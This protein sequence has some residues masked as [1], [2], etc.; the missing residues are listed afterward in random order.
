MNEIKIEGE[1]KI[2]P[3]TIK[4]SDPGVSGGEKPW[5]YGEGGEGMATTPEKLLKLIEDFYK[6]EL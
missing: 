4:A 3:Y 6:A 5:I 2:G 1:L